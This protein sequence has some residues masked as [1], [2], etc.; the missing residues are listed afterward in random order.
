MMT[1]HQLQPSRRVAERLRHNDESLVDFVCGGIVLSDRASR[2]E[3]PDK[4]GPQIEAS[5]AELGAVKVLPVQVV[6]DDA[7]ALLRAIDELVREGAQL[8]VTS[9]GTGLG[10][11]DITPETLLELGGKTVPGFGEV[12]RAKGTAYTPTS[13]LSRS[14]AVVHGETLIVAMPGNPKAVAECFEAI[15]P[16]LPHALATMLK[17]S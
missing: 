17:G 13:Y 3:Y 9:G 12:M 4:A 14:V 7:K 6:P 11:K 8:V 2:G 10:P 1:A 15:A 16:M 5:L